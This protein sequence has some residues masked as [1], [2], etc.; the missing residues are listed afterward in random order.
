MHEQKVDRR[1]DLSDH[2]PVSASLPCSHLT[3][4][5]A[6]LVYDR[7]TVSVSDRVAERI[8][9]DER[10]LKCASESIEERPRGM[11]EWLNRSRS[12]TIFSMSRGCVVRLY[13]RSIQNAIQI[14]RQ[15]SRNHR[16]FDHESTALWPQ[17][18]SRADGFFLYFSFFSPVS[19]W[20]SISQ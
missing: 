1:T 5:D 11:E 6:P 2:Y 17:W 4:G 16:L 14:R 9:Q 12:S 13:S 3:V 8:L 10:W 15:Q 18:P 20:Y 19:T 7:E